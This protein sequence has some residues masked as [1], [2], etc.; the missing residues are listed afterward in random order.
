MKVIIPAKLT[1]SRVPD[2]NWRPFHQDKCLVEIKIEQLL[3]F[4]KPEDI[5]LSCDAASKIS[6]AKEYGINFSLRNSLLA[7][8]ATAWSDVV[9]G[10]VAEIPGPEEEEI[11]WAEVTSP[12]FNEYGRL[13]QLWEQ[14]KSSHDSL[15]SVNEVREFLLDAKGRALNFNYGRWHCPS[16]E[17]EPLYSMDST[18]IMSKK[19]IFYFNYPVGKKPFLYVNQHQSIE[20]DTLQQF[21]MSQRLFTEQ[22]TV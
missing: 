3:E 10:I 15:L 21:E 16:Q 20:I 6:V 18:F 1:S 9:T 14:N 7:A 22:Q 17:L 4:F 2:K 11:L 19:N 8:D 5:Y 12:L 13:L